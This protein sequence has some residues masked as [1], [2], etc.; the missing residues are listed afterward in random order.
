MAER[1]LVVPRL[2]IADEVSAWTM[3]RRRRS[4]GPTHYQWPVRHRVVRSLPLHSFYEAMRNRRY[5]PTACML[6]I[7]NVHRFVSMFEIERAEPREGSEAEDRVGPTDEVDMIG[8][9]LA[10][11]HQQIMLDL[12]ELDIMDISLPW[13]NKIMHAVLTLCLFLRC[14]CDRLQWHN[15][16]RD[17]DAFAIAHV[18]PFVDISDAMLRASTGRNN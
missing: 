9:I 1:E 3:T 13:A 10:V 16:A 6:H 8:F 2:R 11:H 7:R 17:I 18:N 14:E 5:T 4:S 15:A 12:L